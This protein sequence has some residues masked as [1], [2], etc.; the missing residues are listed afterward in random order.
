VDSY[1]ATDGFSGVAG[2]QQQQQQQQR[3]QQNHQQQ[4]QQQQQ[5]R[6]IS[7]HPQQQ[8]AGRQHWQ[9]TPGIRPDAL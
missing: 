2:S 8:C 1:L 7:W 6:H 5:Q 4:Q 3:Q 9:T